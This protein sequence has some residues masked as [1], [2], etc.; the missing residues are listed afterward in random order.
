MDMDIEK[1]VITLHANGVTH[2]ITCSTDITCTMLFNHF[3]SLA[4]CSGY[5]LGS[6]DEAM[7]EVGSEVAD[8]LRVERQSEGVDIW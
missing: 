2:S 4:K 5:M 3:V 1:M 7:V 8:E 6:I